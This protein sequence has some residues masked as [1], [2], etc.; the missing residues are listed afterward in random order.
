MRPFAAIFLALALL[1]APT[2]AK[3]QEAKPATSPTRV[4]LKVRSEDTALNARLSI[5]CRQ[6]SD[7]SPA[8]QSSHSARATRNTLPVSASITST[9]LSSFE[10]LTKTRTRSSAYATP[11]FGLA[12][13]PA[14]PAGPTIGEV[15]RRTGAGSGGGSQS[16]PL[17]NTLRMPGWRTGFYPVDHVF[18]P[19]SPRSLPARLGGTAAGRRS[20][21][22]RGDCFPSIATSPWGGFPAG[23]RNGS[24]R[25]GSSDR[26]SARY[27]RG[28]SPRSAG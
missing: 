23:A 21:S 20:I 22:T 26:A 24:R 15:D 13:N 11:Q 4:L 1:A 10:G 14:C 5:S 6:P 28:G 9:A 12:A 3:A 8:S 19:G 16:F 17:S 27:G 2:L 18:S 25:R 7:H